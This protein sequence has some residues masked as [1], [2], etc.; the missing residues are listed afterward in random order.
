MVKIFISRYTPGLQPGDGAKIS[1]EPGE[2][3]QVIS[4]QDKGRRFVVTSEGRSHADAPPGEYVREGYFEDDPS[5]TSWA[6][7]E[8]TLWF[9]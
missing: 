7:L 5:R 1:W 2:T 4:G 9:A 3:V 6:K 8:K